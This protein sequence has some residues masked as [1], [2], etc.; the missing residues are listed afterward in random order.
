MVQERR[1]QAGKP[2]QEE[3][4]LT[5]A[6]YQNLYTAEDPVE[7]SFPI[8]TERFDIDDGPPTES[9]VVESLMKLR[10]HRAA[11]ATRIRAEDLNGWHF[12]AR[13]E[14]PEEVDP[15]PLELQLWEKVLEIVRL[16]FVEGLVLKA[17]THGI[18]VLTPKDKPNEFWG[19]ALLEIIYK[20]VSSIINRRI[21]LKVTFDDAVHGFWKKWGTS[22]AIMEVK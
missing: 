21:S 10:N 15:D 22:T 2:S 3:I 11:G 18:M 14:K 20:L 17:F 9:E 12:D 6:E 1:P 4:D 5:C 7:E 13:P 8:R 19:V 16:A